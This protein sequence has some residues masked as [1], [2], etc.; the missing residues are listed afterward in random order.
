MPKVPIAT[1]SMAAITDRRQIASA[2]RS[3]LARPKTS[4]RKPRMT[5]MRRSHHHGDAADWQIEP[6]SSRSTR[7]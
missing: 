5:S 3:T 6:R 4:F 1:A 2:A 7:P